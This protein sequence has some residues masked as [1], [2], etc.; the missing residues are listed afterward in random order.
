MNFIVC[1]IAISFSIQ[2]INAFRI[3]HGTAHVHKARSLVPDRINTINS[4][5]RPNI[6]CNMHNDKNEEKISSSTSLSTFFD[7]A[8][9][10]FPSLAMITLVALF[11][12]HVP[13]AWAWPSFDLKVTSATASS[14]L[15]SATTT[16]ATNLNTLN[17]FDPNNFHPVCQ[18][19]DG[20]YGLTKGVANSLLGTENI[21]E[22]GPLVASV[23]L[24]IR[25]ELCVLE[26]FL[27][28]AVIPFIQQ[29]G[30]SWILPLHETLETL[31]TGNHNNNDNFEYNYL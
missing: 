2:S 27:Y 12:W 8:S 6:A 30:I 9:W 1:L 17:L 7:S 10:L 31:I 5:V 19:S 25:L 26:S 28:E 18:V 4:L 22:Y 16:A 24:R 21:V 23:L 14:I 20:F 13:M 3:Q 15:T 29:K 11:S